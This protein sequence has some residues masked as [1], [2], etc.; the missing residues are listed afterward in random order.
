MNVYDIASR[1]TI[2]FK[3]WHKA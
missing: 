3:T 2:I 1:S